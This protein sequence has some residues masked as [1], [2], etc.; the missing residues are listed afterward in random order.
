[1]NVLSQ[2][3]QDQYPGLKEKFLKAA[4]SMGQI[5]TNHDLEGYYEMIDGPQALRK[6]A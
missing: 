3:P 6:H 4:C 1:M 2:C 5:N